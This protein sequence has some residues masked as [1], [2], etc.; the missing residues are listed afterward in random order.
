MGCIKKC[1]ILFIRGIIHSTLIINVYL[2]L[3]Q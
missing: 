2:T 3:I 1:W